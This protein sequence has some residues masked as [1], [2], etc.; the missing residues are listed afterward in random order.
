MKTLQAQWVLRW[1]LPAALALIICGLLFAALS[2]AAEKAD[3]V[4]TARQRDLVT[5]TVSKLQGAI[6]H[7][8]ESATVWDDA[9]RHTAARDLEWMDGNLGTW[10]HTYFGHDA[11][12]V[13]DAAARPIYSFMATDEGVPSATDFERAYAPLAARL[14][15]RL[16][17]GDTGGTSD[18]ILSI[19]EADLTWVGD[20][21]AIVSVKPIVSDSGAV[22]QAPGSEAL[23]VAVR[24]LDRDL[25]AEIGREYVFDALRFS[26]EGTQDP[27][28]SLVPLRSAA[29]ATIGYFQW[30]P[31][32]PGHVVLEATSVALGLMLV[33]IFTGSSLAGTALWR[34]S[35]RLAASQDALRH[36]ASHDSLTGLANRAWFAEQLSERL[37]TAPAD[38]AHGVLF[39]DLDH[40]KEVNDSFGHPVGDRLITL[41]AERMTRLLPDALVARIGGDEFTILLNPESVGR[42]EEIA[43]AIVKVLKQPFEIDAAHVVVGASVGVAVANG[44]C[45]PVELT[46]RADIALYH[47]KAA[48]R[49]AYAIFGTHMDALLRKRRSLEQELREAVTARTPIEVVYQPVFAADGSGPIS[50]EALVRW[51]H[52]SEGP[53]SPAVFIPL[54]EETGLIH[55]IG[56]IVIEEACSMLA[57]LP[58]MTLSIN[59]SSIE[60]QT[61]SYPLKVLTALA[62]WGLQAARLEIELT[63]SVVVADKAQLAR[64][65]RLL[66]EAGVTIAIDDFGTGYSTFS[67]VQ[68]FEIDRIKIDKS[69]IDDMNQENSRALVAA[70]IHMA[71]AKGLKITAEGVETAEQQ[72]A[73]QGLGCDHL[74]GFHLSRPLSRAALRSLVLGASA[75]AQAS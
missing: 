33:A 24:F 39:V 30:K 65:I 7:D 28:F 1:A 6:A 70:M 16:A 27:R 41:A 42:A 73:L 64:S 31:F 60:L 45:D 25:P 43:E 48:G 22:E 3:D 36:Q 17:A 50:L 59:A 2:W 23:H 55:E 40:F 35:V 54:A 38:A 72:Q 51:N 58:G 62:R 15:A 57:E 47:A 37:K 53:I 29:G 69:F 56:A 26:A 20:R 67:R 75:G 32:R 19:G 8:Q 11:A 46:R 61:A 12:I 49:N 4:A 21:P 74:Q 34:R 52:P 63:E 44:I 66:R 68:S 13:L 71:Q 18:R 10:M 5:L 14:Q 9:V